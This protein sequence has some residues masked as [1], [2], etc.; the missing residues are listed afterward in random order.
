[1]GLY[2]FSNRIVTVNFCI[3]L[4]FVANAIRIHT[5]FYVLVKLQVFLNF[6]THFELKSE[7]VLLDFGISDLPFEQS[8]CTPNRTFLYSCIFEVLFEIN[9][10]MLL[11]GFVSFADRSQLGLLQRSVEM[12]HFHFQHNILFFMIFG[13]LHIDVDQSRIVLT[14][15]PNQ[16]KNDKLKGS[17]MCLY[18]L[19]NVF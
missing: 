1:M 17:F 3:T 2:Y 19:R 18:L 5:Y 6:E 14:T 13:S 11:N 9:F 4:A 15:Q 16:L 10:V 12:C 7:I 8:N